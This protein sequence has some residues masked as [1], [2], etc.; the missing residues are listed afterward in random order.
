M[1]ERNHRAFLLPCVGL[2]QLPKGLSAGWV[3]ACTHTLSSLNVPQQA[4]LLK[5]LTVGDVI[6]QQIR[7]L[8][9]Y[10]KPEYQG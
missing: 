7:T 2:T 9:K 6:Q 5:Y 8:G 3:L 10:S 1:R 4:V